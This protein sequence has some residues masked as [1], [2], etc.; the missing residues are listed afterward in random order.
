M[1]FA[2]G[3]LLLGLSPDE[4]AAD[5]K[6][7]NPR[8]FESLLQDARGQS[9]KK[10]LVLVLKKENELS[11]RFNE[12]DNY[13]LDNANRISK[14]IDNHSQQG[15][16]GDD[17]YTKALGFH[18]E[19]LLGPSAKPYMKVISYLYILL[20]IS[21]LLSTSLRIIKSLFQE[22]KIDQFKNFNSY[23]LHSFVAFLLCPFLLFMGVS[24][25]LL[26]MKNDSFNEFRAEYISS[27]K[28]DKDKAKTE[29]VSATTAFVSARQVA[30][31][32]SFY[33]MAVPGNKY[34]SKNHFSFVFKDKFDSSKQKLVLVNKYSAKAELVEN[35]TLLKLIYS[36][37]SLHKGEFLLGRYLWVVFGLLSLVAAISGLVMFCVRYRRAYS[38]RLEGRYA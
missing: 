10:N 9:L 15:V 36:F 12:L 2:S 30:L 14:K 20:I 31:E 33:F 24:G 22:I 27:K 21:G 28:S 3:L 19:L 13:K 34:A 38:N 5:S 18:R 37:Q 1:F 25:T 11:F 26:Y 23:K 6:L 4:K 29:V 7:L 35:S 17:L 32:D 8:V 16:E